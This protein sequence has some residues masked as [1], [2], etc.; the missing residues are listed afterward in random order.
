[1][2]VMTKS[3]DLPY[4]VTE[5]CY[6]NLI[7]FQLY[8]ERCKKCQTQD[9]NF[10]C[11]F[12]HPLPNHHFTIVICLTTIE[13]SIL[14]ENS[15]FTLNIDPFQNHYLNVTSLFPKLT[16]QDHCFKIHK[17]K[18]N[19]QTHLQNPCVIPKS[20]SWVAFHLRRFFSF[21]FLIGNEKRFF[22]LDPCKKSSNLRLQIVPCFW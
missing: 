18:V 14:N 15:N 13:T 17:P 4:A 16:F 5:N 21:F 6:W 22:S 2:Y 19:L 8:Q 1:M 9:K 7:P 11:L 10:V 12:R 3:F 20:V